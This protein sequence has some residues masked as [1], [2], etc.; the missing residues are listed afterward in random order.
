[1]VVRLDDIGDAH[2]RNNTNG[3]FLVTVTFPRE[4]VPPSTPPTVRV[5]WI[6]IPQ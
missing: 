1:M 3:L 6:Q 4:G 2:D 5:R